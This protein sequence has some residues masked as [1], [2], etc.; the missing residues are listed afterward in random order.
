MSEGGR[1]GKGR[2]SGR[3]KK[4]SA[5]AAAVFR[6]PARRDSVPRSSAAGSRGWKLAFERAARARP[7]PL[8]AARVVR[9]ASRR[10][11]VLIV[12]ALA[13]RARPGPA[14]ARAG[15]VRRALRLPAPEV[16]ELDEIS[17]LVLQL[18]ARPAPAT[19]RSEIREGGERSAT[20]DRGDR[21][22]SRA[23]RAL[24]AGRED[25]SS[26]GKVSEPTRRDASR[27]E[28]LVNSRFTNH[29]PWVQSDFVSAAGGGGTHLSTLKSASW[30]IFSQ[31][32]MPCFCTA[33]RSA[34]SSLSSQYPRNGV[35]G[36]G[37]FFSALALAFGAALAALAA[38]AAG[39]FMVA[40][41]SARV[42]A[43][44]LAA[45]DPR[46]PDSPRR[47]PVACDPSTRAT[48]DG[49]A[50]TPPRARAHYSPALPLNPRAVTERT[51]RRRVNKR[52]VED[53]VALR[54]IRAFWRVRFF[55]TKCSLQKRAPGENGGIGTAT[56]ALSAE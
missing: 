5:S 42:D 39:F 52:G 50:C 1:R 47:A 13:L 51:T 7:P 46:A 30:R 56:R 40:R 24:G 49:R 41:G 45:F 29:A 12:R 53:S 8:L 22:R 28:R 16:L 27:P 55:T 38:L 31:A 21:A 2:E 9:V 15:F 44:G 20:V 14:P 4:K 43:R 23:A 25:G 54:R 48:S 37:F 6:N 18:H 17:P 11:P 33:S 19:A 3:M 26:R 34:C 36:A 32:P 10:A 35:C